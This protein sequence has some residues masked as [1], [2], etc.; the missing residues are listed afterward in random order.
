MQE[1]IKQIDFLG[2][3]LWI[4]R[5]AIIVS[6]LWG[7][8]ATLMDNPYSARAWT[9]TI[10]AGIAQGSLYALIAIGYTLVYGVLFM[11]NFAHGEFFM[12]G[13]MT[14]TIFIAQPMSASGYLD[15]HPVIGIT[16]IAVVTMLVSVGIANL[17]E[18]I[19]YRPLRGAPRLVPLITAI[20][21]SFFW[22]YFFQGLYGSEVKAFPQIEVI[23]GK[24]NIAG[25]EIL[26]SQVIVIIVTILMLAGLY[27]FVVKTKT[28]KSI[29]AAAENKDVARLMGIDVD[30]AITLTFTLGASMAGIAGVLYALVFRQI[31]FFMG[32]FPG[33][34]AFT[35][36]V[37]GGI[38]SIPGAALGGLF[39][40][41]FE[42][43]GPGLFLEGLGV[44]SPHQLKDVIAFTMLVLVLI[45]RPQG[46]L[47]EALAEEKA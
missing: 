12:S 13:I 37:L 40:G 24:V 17:T 27:F 34:K 44:P 15:R 30:R 36:A 47:G 33:I 3:V 9:D 16:V 5:T 10:V 26:K 8:I 31:H 14:A 35:A 4:F 11:I 32:F 20:G 41:I 23:V 6:M 43:V 42:S 19:A 21:A 45:F 46:I 29:R 39:L 2:L 22:Q 1:R 38:G 28:G 18:R 25:I 7:T